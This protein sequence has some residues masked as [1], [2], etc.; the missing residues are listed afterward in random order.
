MCVTLIFAYNQLFRLNIVIA[1][2]TLIE[3]K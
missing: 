3:S 2:V 1:A